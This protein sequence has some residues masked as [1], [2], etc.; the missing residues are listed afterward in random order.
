LE[1]N[2]SASGAESWV[3]RFAVIG[4]SG[5]IALTSDSVRV[6]TRTC[7]GWWEKT[8]PLEHLSP[9]YGTL[10]GAPPMYAMCWTFAILCVS[11]G[12]CS[13]IMPPPGLLH[14]GGGVFV[15]LFG[16]WFM[17]YLWRHRRAKWIIFPFRVCGWGPGICYTRQGPDAK[18]C[19]EFTNEMV[20]AIRSKRSSEAEER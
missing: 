18:S 10:T 9:V 17:W 13:T 8:I 12:V 16:L 4:A 5:A 2:M 20:A 15:L 1:Q 11:A 19:D 14:I 7:R 3:Y 6:R